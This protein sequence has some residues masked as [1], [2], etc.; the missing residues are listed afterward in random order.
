MIRNSYWTAALNLARTY[1]WVTGNHGHK[2]LHHSLRTRPLV[3]AG[4]CLPVPTVKLQKNESNYRLFSFAY[5]TV[6]DVE[7]RMDWALQIFL[8]IFIYSKYTWSLRVAP[9]PK[10]NLKSAPNGLIPY[11]NA[12]QVYH[13]VFVSVYSRRVPHD[14]VVVLLQGSGSMPTL[15]I[16]T[17]SGALVKPGNRHSCIVYKEQRKVF[18][19]APWNTIHFF[20]SKTADPSNF[21]SS[22]VR[23]VAGISEVIQR[24]NMRK[25]TIV[26]HYPGYS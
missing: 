18:C 13:C 25:S 15:V 17:T 26:H 8:K 14:R 16:Q 5:L 7:F 2:I 19:E 12:P 1:C 3:V 22:D 6:K 4:L 10:F 11:Q 20:L 24:N 23:G 9:F 21:M